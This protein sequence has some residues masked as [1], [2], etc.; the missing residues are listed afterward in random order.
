MLDAEGRDLPLVSFP[1]PS[2]ENGGWVAEEETWSWNLVDCSIRIRN[3]VIIE[4]NVYS[5]SSF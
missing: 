3:L 4:R 5:V 2:D 1:S